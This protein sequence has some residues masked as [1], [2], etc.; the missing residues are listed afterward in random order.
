[1]EGI[2]LIFLGLFGTILIASLAIFLIRKLKGK[3][4]IRLESYQVP[5]GG[6]INGTVFLKLNKEVKIEEISVSLIGEKT[7]TT[8]TIIGGKSYRNS[9]VQRVFDF[10]L[11]LDTNK[12]IS[13][14]EIS[15]PFSI[16]VP[17]NISSDS[18]SNLQSP[19]GI[20]LKDMANLA[21]SNLPI[22]WY[23]EANLICPGLDLSSKKVK[24]NIA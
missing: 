7:S 18:S 5:P 13:A 17:S 14:G 8:T 23:L 19:I 20:V 11:P 12:E 6:T 2:L 1:M 10:T 9:Y 22:R 15:Y 24:I 4:E 21:G 3:I 16:K